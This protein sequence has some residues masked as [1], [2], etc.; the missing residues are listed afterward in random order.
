VKLHLRTT[1]NTLSL[2][3]NSLDAEPLPP[4]LADALHSAPLCSVS[5]RGVQVPCAQLFLAVSSSSDVSVWLAALRCAVNN[6][7]STL[8]G[9]LLFLRSP[10]VVV[11]HPR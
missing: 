4:P 10:F 2:G 11:V 5:S 6:T 1:A 9:C 3:S 8:A 7:P